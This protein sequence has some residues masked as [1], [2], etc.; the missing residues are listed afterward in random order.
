MP[1]GFGI[2]VPN[3]LNL[4]GGGL[5]GGD[6]FS[7]FFAA[8]GKMIFN[9]IVSTAAAVFDA[10]VK[11]INNTGPISF[12]PSSWW[13]TKVGLANAGPSLWATVIGLSLAVMLGCVI[14]AAILWSTREL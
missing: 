11:A 7:S 3:P 10:V 13:G 1:S 14:L 6:P 2:P 12:A 9:W 5:F 4:F 8:F